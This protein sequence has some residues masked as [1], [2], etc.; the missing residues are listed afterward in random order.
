MLQ[1]FSWAPKAKCWI[2]TAAGPVQRTW[3][4]LDPPVFVWSEAVTRHELNPHGD[5]RRAPYCQISCEIGSDPKEQTSTWADSTRTLLSPFPWGR[6]SCPL[7]D[8]LVP[9]KEPPTSQLIYRLSFLPQGYP[10]NLFTYQLYR[11]DATLSSFPLGHPYRNL[12]LFQKDSNS[13]RL[14]KV[15]HIQV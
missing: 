3:D 4:V 15:I 10:T 13:F 9:K 8:L 14:L 2:P 12:L 7:P 1:Q 11:H 5:W 6:N